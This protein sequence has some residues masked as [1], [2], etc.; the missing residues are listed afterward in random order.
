MHS[1]IALESNG[2]ALALS[3]NLSVSLNFKNPALN[4]VESFS[5]PFELP[6]DGNRDFIKIADDVNAKMRLV[7]IENGTMRIIADG[8]P[9]FTGKVV[10]DNNTVVGPRFSFNVSSCR[11]SF[12]D[13]IADLKC[14]DIPLKDEIKI[15]EILGDVHVVATGTVTRVATVMVGGHGSSN[16]HSEKVTETGT[17]TAEQTLN[18]HGLGFSY[19]ARCVTTGIY[20]H[21][22]QESIRTY[23]SGK[24]EY[25]LN[26]P[27]I[28]ESYINVTDEY[29]ANSDRWGDGGAKYCNMRV[30]YKHRGIDAEGKTT[31]SVIKEMDSDGNNE[32]IW[33][34]WV[35]DAQRPMSG[36]CFYV[37][38]FL[39]CLFKH[40]GIA[41]DNSELLKV[42]DMKHLCFVSTQCHFS[43]EL[44]HG[45]QENPFF[46][47]T[48]DPEPYTADKIRGR[49]DD[50]EDHYPNI[51]G[52]MRSRGCGGKI[53]F[54]IHLPAMGKFGNAEYDNW[55]EYGKDRTIQEHYVVTANIH[56][57][58]ATKDNF[59]NESVTTLIE[60][61]E[62]AFG[63][64]F[65][66]DPETN[67]CRAVFLRDL[68]R[69]KLDATVSPRKFLGEVLECHP[70]NEK[71]LGVRVHY[72]DEAAPE[73]QREYL[74]ERRR[75]YDTD[76]NY[77]DFRKEN[78]VWQGVS[79]ASMIRNT[80]SPTDEHC[81]VDMATGNAYRIKVDAD[82]STY[83]ELRPVIFQV[84]HLKGVEIGNCSK[85]KED[86]VKDIQIGFSP[87][88]LSDINYRKSR[89]SANP[90]S[91]NALFVD[92]DMEHE[93]ITQKLCS[94]ITATHS[95]GAF[96]R[97][98]GLGHLSCY[99]I[100]NLVESY[101]PTQTEYGDSPLQ[102]LD[103]GLT[104]ALMRGGGT[105]AT[106]QN[107]DEGYDGFGNSKWQ[108]I[109]G[110]YQTDIDTMDVFGNA[111]DYNGDRPGD[112]GGE[113]FSLKLRAYKPFRYRYI[114]GE[115]QFSTNS[116]E[117]DDT[118]LIP[119]DADIY[120][121]NVV[122][123]K[124]RSRGLVDTFLSELIN[125]YLNRHKLRYKILTTVAQLVDLRNHWFA[126]WDVDGKICLID[127][128]ECTIDK[129]TG[130]GE[131][132]MDVYSM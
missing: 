80:I 113:R 126:W 14:N 27:K 21:A 73:D 102:E 119:C 86:F 6:C 98:D 52:W 75:D 10:T 33:P 111:Y 100:L 29:G 18:L 84:A 123:K 122:T 30:C 92:E 54:G 82:A 130:L 105:D 87:A 85:E 57:M 35:L 71:I 28:A 65:L 94:E 45:T 32:D 11:Q 118:W 40:L 16:P 112:G 77:T 22:E 51:N 74:R 4:D 50:E 67:S 97:T 53:N 72:S 99:E 79:F 125:F 24:Q 124:I 46:R 63:I 96:T 2:K 39:D 26:I 15:G 17:Y 59:P 129:N 93:F 89:S 48:Y 37:L 68:F 41:W 106:V 90:Y 107:Y 38:Y 8:L 127:S 9:L 61:L 56:S 69:N 120:T 91:V 132:I 95:G 47:E 114:E 104:L 60:S 121:D 117:W 101:D 70:V 23:N 110:T 20:E 78:T 115:L 34:Y 1:H 108:T 13:M 88:I 12:K 43:T 31:D 62:A 3:D 49:V 44:L 103:L 131:V 55:T 76:Y 36:M 83:G 42:E 58:Y 7:E 5:Y 66:Y 81:Y 109:V 19:P 116:A 64:R 128:V 25:T